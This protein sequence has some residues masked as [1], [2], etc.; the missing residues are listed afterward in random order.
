MP[1]KTVEFAVF[2]GGI[3]TQGPPGL[4]QIFR[5]IGPRT[6]GPGCFAAVFPRLWRTRNGHFQV[7]EICLNLACPT[8][9]TMAC[10]QLLSSF[11]FIP[12]PILLHIDER[13]QSWADAERKQKL[14]MHSLLS[15]AKH[16]EHQRNQ[17]HNIGTVKKV[18]S[19]STKN[20]INIQLSRFLKVTFSGYLWFSCYS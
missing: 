5:P 6:V 3:C 7:T 10:L 11:L 9:L 17:L 8:L 13:I 4:S 16:Y 20:N 2:F 19:V 18:H 15:S 12:N 1:P 14:Q